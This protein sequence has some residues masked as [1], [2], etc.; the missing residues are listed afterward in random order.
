MNSKVKIRAF[1]AIS[2]RESS[3]KF[4][5]G[6]SQV[7]KAHGITKVTSLNVEWIED[8]SVFVILVES[9]DGAKVYG[10][11]RVHAA[12]GKTQLPIELATGFMDEKVYDAVAREMEKGTGELCGLW[13]SI[14]VAGLGIGSFFSTRAGVII[15]EQI[16]LGS[17][18][19][20]CA[21][22]TVPWAEKVGCRVLTEVGENGTFYYP[23]IDLL[24]TAVLL[25]DTNSLE[26]A[27]P[28]EKD[29]ILKL[30]EQPIQTLEENPPGK[31]STILID[32]DLKIEDANPGEFKIKK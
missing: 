8:P 4:V 24:A 27:L 26:N 7:L 1:R 13:N 28:R 11:A 32:Y 10:G 15:C 3:M 9:Q 25:R 17:L 19:A 5:K 6:H 20:L 2:D 23:K 12:S 14:E 30:R 21:P 18:F 22:Y 31:K 16:G 29:K